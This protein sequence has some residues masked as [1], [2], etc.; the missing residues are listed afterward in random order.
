M[1]VSVGDWKKGEVPLVFG[2]EPST[3]LR[4]LYQIIASL[5]FALALSRPLIAAETS[6][7]EPPRPGTVT[8]SSHIAKIIHQRCAACHHDGQAAPFNLLTYEDVRKRSKQILEVVERG[9][10]PPW[11]AEPGYGEFSNERRLTEE[12]KVLLRQWVAEGVLEGDPKQTPSPPQWASGWLEGTPDLVVTMP[13]PYQLGADGPDVYRNF[14]IRLPLER[15]RLVRAVEFAPGNPKIV[16]HAFIRVDE[17]R[18]ARKLDGSDGEPGF[19]DMM[20]TARMP[21]G[22]FLTWNPGSRPIVS[23]SRLAWRLPKNSDLVIQLHLN[24]TG[25][26]ETIQSSVGFYFTEEQPTNTCFTLKLGSFALNFPA[27]ATN[28]VARDS[29]VL[30]VDID[31]LA[32]YPHAHFLGREIQA[33]AI[34]PDGVKE[35][36]VWIKRWDF[37]WQGDYRYKK[38]V[39]LPKGSTLH[40]QISYDNSTNN[41]VNPNQPPKRVVYGA[42]SNDEM[43]ELGL[44]VLT[45]GIHELKILEEAV[46][47]H[48]AKLLED[49]FRHR[50]AFNPDDAEARIQLAILLWGDK[51]HQEAWFHL[52]HALKVQPDL[53]DGHY[54]KGVFL[55]MSGRPAEARQELELALRLDARFPRAHQQLGF[56][57]AELGRLVE[58]ERSFEKA[59]QLDPADSIS[60]DGLTELRQFIK[61]RQP[62]N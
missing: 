19:K 7:P 47:R 40:L 29:L 9:A 35:W 32:V 55:R 21:G 12:E 39:R 15:D 14:V 6:P 54:N 10:M 25:K 22:Q 3:I 45:A 5:G 17:E 18:Q 50:M 41:P 38:P 48:L 2:P 59:L 51:R 58:A 42:R 60:L 37:N 4:S 24:R 28:Q 13:Q 26:P 33:Y 27:G 11:L 43:C 62:S 46:G 34:R 61:S 8:F 44:Q 56:A 36:L 1:L 53:P 57:L 20:T 23:P 52:D 30:P 31:V 16:H 49:G